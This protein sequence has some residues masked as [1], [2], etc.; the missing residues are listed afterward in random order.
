MKSLN[1]TIAEEKTLEGALNIKNNRNETLDAIAITLTGD[2]SEITVV[3]PASLVLRPYQEYGITI[4]VNQKKSAKKNHYEGALVAAYKGFSLSF[5]MS[6]RI[7]H[8]NTTSVIPSLNQTP[9]QTQ[10]SP[11]ID[12]FFNYSVQPPHKVK[13]RPTTLLGFIVVIVFAVFLNLL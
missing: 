3:Q 11:D 8:E 7:T 2:L 13:K 6:F 5:P 1:R 4:T 12:S 9:D 10:P